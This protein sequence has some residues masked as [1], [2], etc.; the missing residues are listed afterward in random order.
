MQYMKYEIGRKYCA[1]VYWAHRW[2][3]RCQPYAPAPL[4]SPETL[5][6]ASGTNFCLR[7]SEPQGLVRLEW[8][9]KLKKFIHLIGS[10]T[11]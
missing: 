7:L 10:R 3:W 9:G 2:R 1:M 8:L 6:F 5:F 4:Y 11:R